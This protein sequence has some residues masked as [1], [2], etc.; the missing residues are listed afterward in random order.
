MKYLFALKRRAR[1]AGV[2]VAV[3]AVLAVACVAPGPKYPF[4]D[5]YCQARA[6]GECS[7]QVILACGIPDASTCV[8][9]REQICTMSAPPGTVYNPDGAENCVNV[10]TAAYADAKLT[11]AES[12]AI[13]SACLPVFNGPGGMGAAC[14]VDDDCQLGAGLRCVLTAN[15]TAGTCQVPQMV[16][17]GGSCA[18]PTEQCVAGYHC[19]L[20]ANCDINGALGAPC[21]ANDPCGVGL[22]CSAAGTC[23]AKSP[24]G[25]VCTSAD[26]CLNGIC[27]NE[28]TASGLCVSE[29]TL[30]PSEP[31]CVAS[32]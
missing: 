19:G 32:R 21:S 15:S 18:A 17:G 26:E 14:Q 12:D 9:N 1:S 27:N 5:S 4:I 10:V 13:N 6:S 11:L 24:D 22:A 7:Q 31:F 30:S 3:A 2:L 16:Q 25:T 28:G 20:T 23:A 29:V 8:A